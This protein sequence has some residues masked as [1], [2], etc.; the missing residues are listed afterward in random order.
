MPLARIRADPSPM[1]RKSIWA[2]AVAV[3]LLAAGCG[4]GSHRGLPVLSITERDFHIS[5]PQRRPRRR[6]TRRAHEQRAGLA[7]AAD[8]PRH[9]RPR[10]RLNADGFTIDEDALQTP[11]GRRTSTPPGQGV[12]NFVVHLTPGRYIV[13]CNMAG[14]AAS[15]MQTSFRVRL[16][17]CARGTHSS[18]RSRPAAA[19]RSPRSCSPSRSTPR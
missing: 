5:A 2:A 13:F 8:H 17:R 14:H 7:R 11:A 18:D 6:A 3:G 16:A 19:R 10:C 1:Q 12:R 9:A 15:G 4:G